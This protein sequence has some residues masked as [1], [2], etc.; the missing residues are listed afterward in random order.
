M[1]FTAIK[2]SNRGCLWLD[3]YT[4]SLQSFNDDKG[5]CLATVVMGPT[6]K[7]NIASPPTDRVYD[8][9]PYVSAERCIFPEPS[10]KKALEKQ[11]TL[12]FS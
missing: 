7:V 3:H 6:V 9:S 8:P 5:K 11:P 1:K 10:P 4:L 2:V 12:Q